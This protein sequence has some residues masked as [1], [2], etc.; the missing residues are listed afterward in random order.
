MA[1]PENTDANKLYTWLYNLLDNYLEER[2]IGQLFSQRVAFRLS[3]EY[4]PEP[5]IAFVKSARLHLVTRGF[6]N[7]PPDLAIEI[8]SPESVERDYEKKLD[9]YEA[10][11]VPE[12]WIIDEDA[13]RVVLLRLNKKGKYAEVRP[14]QGVLASQVLTG[15]WFRPE[16]LWAH[17]RP[18]KRAVLGEILSPKL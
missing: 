12:Y 9:A 8:V 6:V 5:D 3:E 15:F 4:G 14:R 17:P 2:E 7:G 1:S 18:K 16:W 10:F 13:Q 11:G